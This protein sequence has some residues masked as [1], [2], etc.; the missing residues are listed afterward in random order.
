M[1]S[2]EC[3]SAKLAKIEK[4]LMVKWLLINIICDIAM[5]LEKKNTIS[6]ILLIKKKYEY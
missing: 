4:M 3:T 2:D 1:A 5:V 6:T